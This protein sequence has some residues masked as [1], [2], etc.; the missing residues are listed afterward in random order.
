MTTCQA[1]LPDLA[2][3][4]AFGG[5]GRRPDIRA[6][7]ARLHRATAKIGI[8]QA[9]MYPSIRIGAHAGTR[10]LSER[11]HYRLG[12]PQHGPSVRASR[13]PIFDRAAASGVVSCANWSSRRPR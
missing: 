9:D 7:E 5:C 4:F 1:A 11:G 6:A 2:A 13:L 8:G 12:Q 10:I 3:G